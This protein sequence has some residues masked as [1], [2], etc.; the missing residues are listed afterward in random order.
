M[1]KKILIL[2]LAVIMVFSASAAVFAERLDDMAAGSGSD[3]VEPLWDEIHQFT[4]HFDISSSGRATLESLMMAF[5]V[6]EI[7]VYTQLQQWD[8]DEW[9]TIKSW[10]STSTD[11]YGYVDAAKYVMS[12]NSYRMV[13]TGTVYED[14][15]PVES[16]TYI[17]D[18]VD[19]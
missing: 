8:D 3:I 17:S 6:D 15:S 16:N 13:S 10:R 18:P 12:K 19:Y 9:K 14:G 7:K 4:N 11:V 5:D 1:I 2:M